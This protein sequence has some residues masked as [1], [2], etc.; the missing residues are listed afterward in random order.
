[1]EVVN[2]NYS[3]DGNIKYGL[4]VANVPKTIEA[5]FLSLPQREEGKPRFVACLSSQIGCYFDCRMCANM[6]SSY[7]RDL[8]V[9]EIDAQIRLVLGNDGNLQKV[10]QEGS[11]EYA[12]MGIGEPLFGANVIRSIQRHKA[13]VPDTRFVISTVGIP[14]S[15]QKLTRSEIPYPTRL[16]LSLHFPNDRLRNEWIRGEHIFRTRDIKLSIEE[17]LCEASEYYQR[18]G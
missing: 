8:K 15:I 14:G 16:E 10:L 18:S 7:M 6:F 11:V 5:A 4:R 9:S 2:T 17:M 12:F 13:Y 1:M 3:S